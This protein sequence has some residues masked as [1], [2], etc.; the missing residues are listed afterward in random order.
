MTRKIRRVVAVH[1][2]LWLKGILRSGGV[3]SGKM[4]MNGRTSSRKRT[5]VT[6]RP[7]TLFDEVEG[8]REREG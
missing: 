8:E 3:T 7:G 2:A 1:S 4:P 6:I 5:G